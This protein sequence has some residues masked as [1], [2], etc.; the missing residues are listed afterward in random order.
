MAGL[1]GK[2]LRILPDSP[3]Y[4]H[5]LVTNKLKSENSMPWVSMRAGVPHC[6]AVR[7][8]PA[9]PD[10]APCISELGRA[11][12]APWRATARC[13]V[14]FG[15]VA[16]SIA[17]WRALWRRGGPH[18]A[19]ACTLAP[20]RE[21]LPL[22]QHERMEATACR[23]GSQSA[24]EARTASARANGKLGGRPKKFAWLSRHR[25]AMLLTPAE[26]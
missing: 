19:L 23:A 21:G 22:A 11:R 16:G 12:R 17:L 9:T 20:W 14:H 26:N 24:S 6:R 3:I 18:R 10:T 25:L 7:N 2:L 4:S 8:P 5:Q 15:A 13:D 1:P